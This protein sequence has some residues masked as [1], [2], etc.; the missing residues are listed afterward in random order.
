MKLRTASVVGLFAAAVATAAA[1]AAL[2]PGSVVQ[3]WDSHYTDNAYVR[4]DITQISPKVAGYV[5][6][7]RVTDNQRVAAGDVL[8]RID[9]RDYRAKLQQ[10]QAAVA[11]RRAAVVNLDAQITLQH[12]VIRQANAAVGAAS[13]EAGRSSRDAARGAQLAS[14]QLIAASSYDQLQSSAESAASRVAETQANAAAAQQRIAVLESQRPQLQADIRAAEAAVALAQLDVESTTVRAPVA[15]RVS[16]RIARVGQ[17]VRPGT[18]LIGLVPTELW[19]VANFKETQLPGMRVGDQVEIA[20]DAVPDATFHGHLESL[21]P[22]SGAQFAL[23]PPDNATGNFT[24]IV[25]RVP[26]RIALDDARELERLLPGMS[27]SVRVLD[28]Q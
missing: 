28:A 1:A 12:A 9:D 23:L 11:A 4:G 3:S 27:A 25:Q 21:S 26:V 5:V 17:Y 6:D 13:T 19:V 10:A 22:A 15:G 24:R 18:Q 20:I 2:H 16:E 14:Q 8:F 7:V